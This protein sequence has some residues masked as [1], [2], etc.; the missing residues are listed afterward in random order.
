MAS[1]PN[2][3]DAYLAL[4]PPR[5]RGA[6]ERLRRAIRSAAPGASECLMYGMPAFRVNGRAL[7]AMRA[8]SKHCALHPM[9]GETLRALAPEL[10]GYDTSPGTLRFDGSRPLPVSLVRKIVRTRLARLATLDAKR[11]GAA[12]RA[13]A[14]V[15]RR[16]ASA[17]NP[18][19]ARRTP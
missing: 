7:V 11:T 17:R 18:R 3:M 15:R 1:K 6:L 13:H 8:A 12:K 16:G 19:R 4:L 10:A 14:K 9:D 5:E 2:T